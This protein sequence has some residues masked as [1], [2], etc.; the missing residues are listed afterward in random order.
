MI[1]WS[2][3][4]YII[5]YGET[6]DLIL[7]TDKTREMIVDFRKHPPPLQPLHIKGVEK[8]KKKHG[9]KNRPNTVK[10]RRNPVGG[11]SFG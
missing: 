7:N 10:T 2:V 8:K 11:D 9:E 4:N 3:V 5:D 6:N 1:N